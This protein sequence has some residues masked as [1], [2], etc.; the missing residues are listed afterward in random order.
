M[1]SPPHDSPRHGTRAEPAQQLLL[2]ACCGINLHASG[3]IAEILIDLPY[4]FHIV[5]KVIQEAGHTR[6]RVEAGEYQLESIDWQPLVA[7]G[8]VAVTDV[9]GEDE[10]AAV[11]AFAAARLDEGE[12][13][14]CAVA[15][16]RGYAI[17]TDDRRA[18]RLLS[19]QG[20]ASP[21]LSTLDLLH[22]WA[23]RRGLGDDE[24]AAVV[25]RVAVGGNFAPPSRDSLKSWW[26]R[27]L[28][29]R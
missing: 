10:E 15:V 23:N 12:A 18:R 29:Q 25:H 27:L 1:A 26:E 8:L 24:V 7:A 20:F 2:D 6:R 14:T 11:V 17:A 5:R 9:D 21:V 28:S 3:R 16:H 4:R 22:Q 19:A 13:L